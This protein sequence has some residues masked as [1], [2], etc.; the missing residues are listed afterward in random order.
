MW[1]TIRYQLTNGLDTVYSQRKRDH[2]VPR[3]S[4]KGTKVI[5]IRTVLFVNAEDEDA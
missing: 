3:M 5:V 1:A 2:M 4:H